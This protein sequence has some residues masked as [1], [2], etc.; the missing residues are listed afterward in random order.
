MSDKNWHGL[1]IVQEIQHLNSKGIVLWEAKKL[2]NL[3]VNSGEQFILD[4]V[5]AGGTIPTS[6]FLA[7]DNRAVINVTDTISSFVA[8]PTSGGYSRQAV[9]DFAV[10]FENGNWRAVS[11][12][13]AFTADSSGAGTGWGPVR[14]LNLVTGSGVS[15]TV[16]ISSTDLGTSISLSPGE[17]VTVRMQL[18]M[19]D[20]S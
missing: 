5:F 1:M 13:V 7:L 18:A 14:N 20:C 6:Y 3:F 9:S 11:P 10:I 15:G 17:S 16:L 8:E 4:V 12:I 19:K 2:R